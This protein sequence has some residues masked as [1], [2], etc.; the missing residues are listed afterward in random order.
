MIS[1]L[2][3]FRA[4]LFIMFSFGYEIFPWKSFQLRIFWRVFEAYLFEVKIFN[5]GPVITS[6]R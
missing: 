6:K 1:F 5:L 2:F 4:G 3:F